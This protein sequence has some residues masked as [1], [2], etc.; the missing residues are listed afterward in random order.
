MGAQDRQLMSNGSTE[1]AR[2]LKVLIDARKL[3]QGGIGV[4][5]D[6]LISGLCE[7]SE[8]EISLIAQKSQ[9]QSFSWVDSI[10]LIEDSAPLYSFDELWRMPRRIDMSR[11]DLFHAPHFTLPYGILIPTVVTVHDL[12]QIRYPERF[13]YP[14]IAKPLIRS[15]LRRA[16]RVLTV[17]NATYSDLACLA[18]NDQRIL[19]KI[20][21]VPNALDPCFSK[22]VRNA[23]FVAQRFQIRGKYLLSVFSNLKPHKGLE[24]LLKAFDALRNGS[25]SAKGFADLK[26]VLTG[27]GMQELVEV[28][29]LLEIAGAIKGVHILGRV[30][31]DE[32]A[33]LY[34]NAFGV[35]IPSYAD[36]FCLP[37]LEAQAAGVPVL[38]RPTPAVRELLTKRDHVCKDYSFSALRQG[39]VSYVESRFDEPLQA[40]P[41]IDCEHLSKFCRNE[42]SRVVRLVYHE[43]IEKAN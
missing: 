29:R 27:Q 28:E 2:P 13:Y 11:Y 9:V 7:Q 10:A 18:G 22:P 20:R 16:S 17:S 43:A 26:L 38:V 41:V 39:L 37:V 21:V 6:N 1:V 23:D 34:A 32:L 19:R 3:G 30:K 35:V 31:K 33:S 8:I 40:P 36:G 42:L 5:L 14:W 15:A 12:I 4:Y 24:D 25:E